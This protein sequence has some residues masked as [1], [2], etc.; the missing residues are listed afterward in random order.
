MAHHQ[1][2]R[3]S[4]RLSNEELE[5][6]GNLYVEYKIRDVAV[7]FES[8]LYDPEYYLRKHGQGRWRA[9][10]G[11]ASKARTGLRRYLRMGP[12]VRTPTG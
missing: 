9:N 8:F 5:Y 7:D 4:P 2:D 11:D 6:Y 3:S 10:G 1:N 12:A